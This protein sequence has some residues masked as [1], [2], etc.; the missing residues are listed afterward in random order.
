M[1]ADH[2]AYWQSQKNTG[3]A[4]YCFRKVKNGPVFNPSKRILSMVSQLVQTD[5]DF[6]LWLNQ[7]RLDDV[8]IV[9]G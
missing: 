5:Q 9:G 8:P 6:V 1:V 3:V 7:I 2:A 4:F